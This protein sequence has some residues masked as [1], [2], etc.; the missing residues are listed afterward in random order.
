MHIHVKVHVGGSVVHTGQLFFPDALTHTVYKRAPYAPRGNPDTPNAA[1]TRSSSTA[2]SA[3][4]D[5]DEERR[6]L[7]RHD[8]DGR[9]QV[10]TPRKP[11][12]SR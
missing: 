5:G 4:L 1:A 9:A 11:A 12:T 10:R 3:V 7:P 6:R 2:A 8:R